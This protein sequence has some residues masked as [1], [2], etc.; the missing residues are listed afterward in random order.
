MS[1][2][3]GGRTP[4]STQQ[5]T[6]FWAAWAGWMLD[7][8]DSFIYAL[9]L[10]PAMREL[11]PKSGLSAAPKDVA[12][13]GSVLF[14]LFLVGWGLSFIWGPIA[15]R[16]GR[17]RTL[18]G[19]VLIY[20]VFTGAAALAGNVWE[21]AAFRFLAGVGI[22]G[23]WAMAGT[24]VAE[25]W[26]EDRRRQGA[27]YLQTGYYAGFFVAAVLNATVGA[28]YG[29]RAMFLCGLTPVVVSVVTL[30]RVREPERWQAA[31]GHEPARRRSPLAAIRSPPL[32]RRTLVNTTL[33]AVAII[34]L[35]AGAVYEPTAVIQLARAA[36]YQLPEAQRMASYAT[37]LLSTGTIIGCLILPG[38][39][40]RIGRRWTLG[41]Y[42]T[43][44]AVTIAA[45]FGWA[46]YLPPAQALPVFLAVLFFLGVFGGNF[47]LF[48]LWLPEQY[49]TEVRATAFAFCTSIGRFIGA[50]VNFALAAGVAR[51]G[52]LGTP[53]ALT[54]IAFALGLLIIPA[55][56][57]TRGERLPA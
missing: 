54:A 49:T 36:G 10:A 1:G 14:G 48:S 15:D 16:F 47:A 46:F 37:G 24:Y 3:I 9:V 5:I 32:L 35:W 17:T 38:I 19:T 29:W 57:E 21:L 6:G 41:A 8:M 52:T 56:V 33:V 28:A 44:M 31:H 26:P 7:G 13:A 30:L 4:L 39:A 2:R 22:G 12:F 25:A 50:G 53:V 45:S 27:G 23:E 11:L 18:A 43:G 34:G 51:M 40:D 42:F 20:S 55:A